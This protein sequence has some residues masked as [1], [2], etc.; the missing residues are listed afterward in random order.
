[1]TEASLDPVDWDAYRRLAHE[2]ID[3]SIDYLRTVR[4]RPVW[5]PVPADVELS[6]AF[7]A[8]PIWL[9]IKEHG[10]ARLGEKIAENCDQAR[11]LAS[12]ICERSE[13]ELCAPASLDIVCFRFVGTL[14]V[15]RDLDHLNQELVADLQEQ[16]IAAP[17]T[18]RLRDRVVIRVAITNH[19]ST[20]ADFD[21]LLDSVVKLG[22]A[23]LGRADP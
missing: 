11:Y 15:A 17:S 6:R 22:R 7:R 12:R 18:T 8:L 2:L 21:L 16:G 14:G 1:M 9:T 23:R 19:R 13:L 3:A 20:R 5:Q 4:D 10:A